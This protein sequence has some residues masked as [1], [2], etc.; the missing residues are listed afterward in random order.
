MPTPHPR[1]KAAKPA[2]VFRLYPEPATP[3]AMRAPAQAAAYLSILRD[4]VPVSG[5]WLIASDLARCYEEIAT[6]EEWPI[7][8]WSAIGRELAKLTRRK[9][10]K[11]YG[12]RHV[13][14]LLK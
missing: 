2:R 1:G 6:K 7:L 12:R 10:I 5:H 9:T 13:A 4:T 3:S 14:Y 11:R 8:H